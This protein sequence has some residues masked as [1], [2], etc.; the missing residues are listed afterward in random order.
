MV[1]PTR[2]AEPPQ[3]MTSAAIAFLARN[4]VFIFVKVVYQRHLF[5]G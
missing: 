1:V 4:I 3:S 5:S 2:S